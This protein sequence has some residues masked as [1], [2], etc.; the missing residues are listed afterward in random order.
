MYYLHGGAGVPNFGDELIVKQWLDFLSDKIKGPVI[1]P[2]LRKNPITVSGM[3]ESVLK[4]I[5]SKDYQNV[6]FTSALY[7][8]QVKLPKGYWTSFHAGYTFF[9]DRKKLANEELKRILSAEVFHLHGGGY[10]NSIWP[11]HA[12]YIGFS[13]ALKKQTGCRLVGTGLGLNPGPVPPRKYKDQFGE[14]LVAF[15]AIEVRD[16]ASF[17]FVHEY[18]GGMANLTLGLDDIFLSSPSIKSGPKTFHISLHSSEGTDEASSQL[19]YEF[20]NSFERKVFWQCHYRD[21]DRY[22]ELKKL[23]PSLVSLG[24]MALTHDPLPIGPEDFMITSRF[25]PHMQSARSGLNGQ[26]I[27]PWK[28]SEN[29]HGSVL[30]LGSQFTPLPKMK[31]E[32]S[33]KMKNMDAA[34]TQQKQAYWHKEIGRFL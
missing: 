27:A 32:P 4:E 21:A 3:R 28:Y 31:G 8:Y 19:D 29:K 10:I 5:F 34:R 17:D 6:N 15:D 33:L 18:S 1:L 2:R 7:R 12:F 26:Y 23:I 24:V 16:E 22:H 20:I 9:D 14:A 13:A 25:H 11:N 30:K